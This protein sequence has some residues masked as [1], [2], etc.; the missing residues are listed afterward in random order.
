MK[1]LFLLTALFL[2]G[3]KSFGFYDPVQGFFDRPDFKIFPDVMNKVNVLESDGRNFTNR[4]FD[5]DS[6]PVFAGFPKT[7]PGES[8]EGGIFCQMDSDPELEIVYAIRQTIQAWNIDGSTVPGWP[9]NLSYV[10]QGAPSYGDIDGDGQAE[11]V[12]GTANVT[13]SAGAIYAF[14]KNGTPVTGFPV[15]NGGTSRTIVLADLNNDG[16]LEIITNKR[17]SSAGEVWV[18]K[19]DGT[20]YPGWPQTINH[21]PASSSAVGDITGDGIPEIISESYLSL[22]AW[23]RDGNLL[24]GFP[25]SMPNGDVNSYSSPVIADIDDDNI[26]EILFG[27]HAL[28]GTGYLYILKN[29]GTVLNGWPKT[30]SQWIY[31]PPVLGYVNNDN[32][33]DIIVGDQVGSGVP[34]DYLYGWDKDGNVLSG[35]PMGPINAINNQAALGD[36]DN[37]NQLEILVDDNSQISGMGQYLAFNHDG[38]PVS[39]WTIPTIGA[40]FFNMPCLTDLNNDGMLDMV[41]AGYSIGGSNET[42]V[43]IWN[44]GISFDAS[45]IVNP[46]WQFNPRH[47]GVYGDNNI[48]SVHQVSSEIPDRFSLKQNYPNPFNPVTVIRYSIPSDVRGQTSKIKLRVYDNLGKQI[49]ELVNEAQPAGSYAVDFNGS[50]LSSGIYFYKLEAGNFSETKSMVLLK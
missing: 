10:A 9:V 1:Y 31:A 14:E 29:D 17:L 27:S 2:C 4:V 19:G 23:D 18:F 43:Y 36:I 26:P 11:I 22:Y 15:N 32:I 8:F 35:F 34:A 38:T 21:V 25:F 47:N 33:I 30:T 20:V 16:S 41:G 37:D 40:S 48:V 50:D 44:T 6:F 49:S 45:K 7:V 28:S 42:N 12:V 3:D 13:G 5:A 46:V 24:T 39:G